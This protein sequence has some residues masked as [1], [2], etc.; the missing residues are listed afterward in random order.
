MAAGVGLTI[1]LGLAAL[2]AGDFVGFGS[3][4][5]LGSKTGRSGCWI[6]FGCFALAG[7]GVAVPAGLPNGE[8]GIA[9]GEVENWG[10]RG[11]GAV[12]RLMGIGCV[13]GGAAGLGFGAWGM[14]CSSL[15]VN[16]TTLTVVGAA[17]LSAFSG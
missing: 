7:L 6:V 1:G 16:S 10:V 17:F 4:K 9:C 13:I 3:V 8:K 11:G 14:R 15:G 2:V 5:I 12:E